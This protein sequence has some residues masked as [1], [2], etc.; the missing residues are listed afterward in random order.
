[1]PAR[2]LHALVGAAFVSLVIVPSVSAQTIKKV[3]AKRVAS[4]SGSATFAAYCAACHGPQGKGNGPAA[5]ALK[6]APADL[7]TYSKR[8]GG[9]FSATD[10][11]AK[12]IGGEPMP[13]HGSNEMPIWGPV[14]RDTSTDQMER[15][16]RVQNIVEYIRSIQVP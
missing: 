2:L 1:M 16:L 7:T 13:A 5:A 11:E 6:V 15:R 10:V 8:H 9:K 12:I 14:F 3:P 4:V